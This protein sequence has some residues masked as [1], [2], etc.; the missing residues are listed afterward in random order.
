MK[1]WAVWI[2]LLALV[3]AL[4]G[5]DGGRSPG[6]DGG[7]PTGKPES[8]DDGSDT[9]GFGSVESFSFS[10]QWGSHGQSYDSKTGV[11]TKETSPVEHGPED[12][13]TAYLLTEEQKQQIYD[14]LAE[15]DVTSYPTKYDPQSGTSFPS[16]S[17][18]L[19]V[20]TDTVQK[21][22]AARD[23][24]SWRFTSEDAKGQAFLSAC[25]TII[26]LLEQTE[27]WQALPEYDYFLD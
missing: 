8:A 24:A 11:L 18:I 16:M 6:K 25:K 15:L 14:L 19:S 23:I 9:R 20:N 12:Y 5:C 4:A 2:V 1:K 13:T 26:D 10:L 17:L 22:I 3:P 27:E 21:T 7:N